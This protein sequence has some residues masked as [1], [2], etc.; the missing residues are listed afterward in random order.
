MTGKA[1]LERPIGGRGYTT[2]KKYAR[3]SATLHPDLLDL[4]DTHAQAR[5]ISRSEMLGRMVEH[6]AKSRPIKAVAVE[7]VLESK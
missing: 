4:L 7:E 3:F 5:G 6:Y 1:K 2:D